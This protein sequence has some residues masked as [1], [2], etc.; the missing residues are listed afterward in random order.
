M[1][2]FSKLLADR[3]AQRQKR[4]VATPHPDADL[5]TAL[6][7]NRLAP[8]ERRHVVAHLA[9]CADC[10][11][12]L[13]LVSNDTPVAIPA[14]AAISWR[15]LRWPLALA[16]SA[17]LTFTVMHRQ[18]PTNVI[19]VPPQARTAAPPPRLEVA[20]APSSPVSPLPAPVH[21][22]QNA[23]TFKIIPAPAVAPQSQAILPPPPPELEK[24]AVLAGAVAQ[25]DSPGNRFLPQVSAPPS[26]AASAPTRAFAVRPLVLSKSPSTLVNNQLWSLDS[27]PPGT[28]RTSDD[29]GSHWTTVRLDSSTSMLSLA[30]A[31]HEVWVGAEHG[32]LFHSTDNG[33]HWNI[34][35][36]SDGATPLLEP[37]TAVEIK[38]NGIV[39]IKS[40][41][42]RWITADDGKTWLRMSSR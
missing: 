26:A 13:S 3:L 22:R 32:T 41:S 1:A 17:L 18:A 12:I 38:S 4:A 10:R 16:A 24:Q 5:L 30:V 28:I 33:S 2:S 29:G 37:I 15:T 34:T 25:T 6:A 23:P 19:P 39:R 11:E 42:T 7:E 20:P 8:K 21:V 31:G 9:D 14:P 36:V 40:P 35:I 27:T